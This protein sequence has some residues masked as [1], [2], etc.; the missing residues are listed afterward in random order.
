[1]EAIPTAGLPPGYLQEHRGYVLVGVAIAF[2]CLET[3]SVFLRFLSH[4]L[5]NIP[6]GIDDLLIIPALLLCIGVNTVAIG[7]NSTKSG[8]SCIRVANFSY[9]YGAICWSRP[10]CNCRRKRGS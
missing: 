2:I 4:R 1:M 10:S 6:T 8:S 5:G 7:E 9:S 3:V